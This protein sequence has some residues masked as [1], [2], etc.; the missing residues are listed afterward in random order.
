[1]RALIAI[2]TLL[3][4]VT[5]L[6]SALATGEGDCPYGPY[7]MRLPANV[8]CCGLDHPPFCIWY[9]NIWVNDPTGMLWDQCVTIG[10]DM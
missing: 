3:L 8:N 5:L 4:A 6:P 10:D 1:M 9:C 2:A 7:E